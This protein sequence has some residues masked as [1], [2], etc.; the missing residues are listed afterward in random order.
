M[1]ASIAVAIFSY[2]TII[3]LAAPVP[4]KVGL[5]HRMYILKQELT[6]IQDGPTNVERNSFSHTDGPIDFDPSFSLRCLDKPN[7]QCNEK[8]EADPGLGGLIKGFKTGVRIFRKLDKIKDKIED[9]FDGG[10]G[11][12]GGGAPK[13]S[14]NGGPGKLT[15]SA[16][17]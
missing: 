5:I 4:S 7:L 13:L 3:S 1:K 14:I 6:V 8:R 9:L 12:G 11:G 10:G 17:R 15:V 2:F 16:G